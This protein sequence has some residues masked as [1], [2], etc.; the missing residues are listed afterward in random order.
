[1]QLNQ[2][3]AVVR[4]ANKLRSLQIM[5]EAGVNVPRF[6]TNPT[7]FGDATFF[8][9]RRSHAGGRDI[10]VF[11]G[12]HTTAVHSDFFTE[13]VPSEREMRLHIFQGELILAQNKKRETDTPE[14]ETPIRNR[15]QGYVFVPL[16]RSRPH[17]SR[18]EQARLAVGSLG[19][20]FGA[21][22][23]LCTPGGGSVVLEVNTAPAL[24]SPTLARAY[25]DCI[26]A[27]AVDQGEE[28]M[29]LNL[30]PWEVDDD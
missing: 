17:E 3:D 22:D 24:T 1:M 28:Q 21:V 10:E 7:D 14:D 30:M 26:S 15:D 4:A 5:E 19:L 13:F 20:D 9:R 25:L 8:G 29:I 11:H 6:S 16:V 2:G 23:L 18:I 27:W 12:M